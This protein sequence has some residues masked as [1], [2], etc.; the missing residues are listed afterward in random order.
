[1]LQLLRCCLSHP[2]MKIST[3]ITDYT[4]E[5]V[6]RF[7]LALMVSRHNKDNETTKVWGSFMILSVERKRG[8]V[9]D[10]GPFNSTTSPLFNRQESSF[11]KNLL[12]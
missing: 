4:L 5:A 7:G 1:M 10:M 12:V 2:C 6:A 3:F 11:Y 9:F 8:G